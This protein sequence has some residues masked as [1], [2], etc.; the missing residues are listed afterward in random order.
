MALFLNINKPHYKC[1]VRK[2]QDQFDDFDEDDD[3]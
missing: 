2:N 3:Y 1:T